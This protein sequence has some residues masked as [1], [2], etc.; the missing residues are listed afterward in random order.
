[1]ATAPFRPDLIESAIRDDDAMHRM[2]AAMHETVVVTREMIEATRA[3]LREA[4]RI[5]RQR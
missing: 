1:M 4:D 3:R 2:A 5:L